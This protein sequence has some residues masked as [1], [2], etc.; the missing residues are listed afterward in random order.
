MH[1]SLDPHYV[2]LANARQRQLTGKSAVDDRIRGAG[3]QEK[4][5]RS[6]TVDADRNYDEEL[7]DRR[8]VKPDGGLVGR[9]G[10]CWKCESEEAQDDHSADEIESRWGGHLEASRRG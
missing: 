7:V 9:G 10:A 3:I 2:L 6:G 5:E 8:E 1:L 4:T